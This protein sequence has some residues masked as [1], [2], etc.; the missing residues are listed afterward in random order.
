[1]RSLSSVLA[2]VLLLAASAVPA[3]AQPDQ[4][5]LRSSG[6]PGQ[7]LEAKAK[8]GKVFTAARHGG[9]TQRWAIHHDDEGRFA[10]VTHPASESCLTGNEPDNVRVLDCIGAQSQSWVVRRAPGG[11]V[12]LANALTPELC[13][14]A[15]GEN[16]PTALH[17]CSDHPRQLWRP[18]GVAPASVEADAV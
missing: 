1:M 4:V 10:V 18:V 11:L 16:R 9:P 13:L 6:L 5:V 14:T 8:N 7:A 17:P 15:L 2:G 3:Q 12:S